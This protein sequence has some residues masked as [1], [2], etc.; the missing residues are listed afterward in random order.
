M[1]D[2][3]RRQR[4]V[5]AVTRCGFGVEGCVATQKDGGEGVASFDPP[6]LQ[7]TTGWVCC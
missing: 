7:K 5:V 3:G 2:A 1:L 4:V 6:S